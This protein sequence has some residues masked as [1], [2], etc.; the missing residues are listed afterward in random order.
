ML[1]QETSTICKRCGKARP[2]QN[3]EYKTCYNKWYKQL[4]KKE[5]LEYE[6]ARRKRKRVEKRTPIQCQNCDKLFI[7]RRRRDE[8]YCSNKCCLIAFSKTSHRQEYLKLW[9]ETPKGLALRRRNAQ[10]LRDFR[11]NNP[12]LYR[13]RMKEFRIRSGRSRTIWSEDLINECQRCGKEFHPKKTV[14]YQ[15]YCS[16][17]CRAIMLMAEFK[18]RNP[19]RVKQIMKKYTLSEKG[20]HMT[21]KQNTLRRQRSFP[22]ELTYDQRKK[23]Q[24]RD[25]SCVYCGSTDSPTFDHIIALANGGTNQFENLVLCCKSCNS[26]KFDLPVE[27]FCQKKGILLPEIVCSLLEEQQKQEKLVKKT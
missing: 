19:E 7:Q 15:K 3:T 14:P 9:K 24:S 10:K 11:K 16:K 26:Q 6:K 25:K 4:K 27:E 12:E 21:F 8:K 20:K 1:S 18:R 22:F 13:R 5:L 2:H 17:N 23:I